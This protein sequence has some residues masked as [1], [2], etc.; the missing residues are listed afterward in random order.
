MLLLRLN[1]ISLG[2]VTANH[3]L[4]PGKDLKVFSL[5]PNCHPFRIYRY[6]L[7]IKCIL[8]EDNHMPKILPGAV[9]ILMM[10]AGA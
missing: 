2:Q 1:E 10:M 5:L 8:T 7:L 4:G 6:N 3:I 9:G